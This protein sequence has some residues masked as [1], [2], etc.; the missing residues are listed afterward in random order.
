MVW[1]EMPLY[2]HTD[3]YVF[4]RC[5]KMEARHRSDVLEPTGRSYAGAMVDAFILMQD[6]ARAHTAQVYMT[7]LD[8]KGIR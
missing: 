2:G 5:G 8:D 4:A 6:N 1:A 3:L 7:I